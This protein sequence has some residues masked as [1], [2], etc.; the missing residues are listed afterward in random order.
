MCVC[1][2]VW[3]RERTHAQSHLTLCYP[4]ACS[5][6][7]SSVHG[8]SQARILEWAAVSFSGIFPSQGLNPPPCIT[9]RFLTTEPPGKPHLTCMV[10][11]ILLAQFTK[12]FANFIGTNCILT[13]LPKLIRKWKKAL[14]LS[15][16][17]LFVTPRMVAHQAPLSLGLSRQAYWSGLPFL[18][19]GDLPNSGSNPGLLHCGK[20]LY[21]LSHCPNSYGQYIFKE[22]I[23][24]QNF[25]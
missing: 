16:A 11:I 3:A 7:D 25:F 5:P 2:C 23:Q 18:S 17:G 24:I 22:E 1:V 14:S 4:T 15:H 19:P 9:G 21:L 8:I 12:S 13:L 10:D 20:I 6:P